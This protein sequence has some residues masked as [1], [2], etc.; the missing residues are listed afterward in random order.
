MSTLF[1]RHQPERNAVQS[2]TS[3]P[4]KGSPP[5]LR[6]AP[7]E[8]IE[9]GKNLKAT[10]VINANPKGQNTR[11]TW[12]IYKKVWGHLRYTLVHPEDREITYFNKS[13]QGKCGPVIGSTLSL[14]ANEVLD[15]MTLAC[16]ARDTTR[17]PKQCLAED[18]TCAQSG[19]VRVFQLKRPS[20]PFSAGWTKRRNGTLTWPGLGFELR[21]SDL[22]ANCPT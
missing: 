6:V 3:C 17:T 4:N 9:L 1:F 21:T 19:S 18:S 11:V 22:V 16:F 14:K 2:E 7:D 13:A 15:R 8:R 10:C 12:A 5:L 20:Y